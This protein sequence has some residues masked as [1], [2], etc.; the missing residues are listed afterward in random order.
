[1]DTELK[2]EDNNSEFINKKRERNRKFKQKKKD[3]KVLKQ[4]KQKAQEKLYE[5]K[6]IPNPSMSNNIIGML[7][8]E[9]QTSNNTPSNITK[10]KQSKFNK[11]KDI[12]EAQKKSILSDSNKVSLE[13]V[14]HDQ[15]YDKPKLINKEVSNV[16]NLT[17]IPKLTNSIKPTQHTKPIT[18]ATLNKENNS[19]TQVHKVKKE[20]TSNTP[21]NENPT[22][23]ANSTFHKEH[24][25]Q[26]T[27]TPKKE[28]HSKSTNSIKVPEKIKNIEDLLINARRLYEERAQEYDLE[29]FLTMDPSKQKKY[30]DKKWTAEIIKTGTF[31]DKISALALYIKSE[32]KYTLKY[33]D[34]LI[35]MAKKKNRRQTELCVANF[36]NVVYFLSS[37]IVSKN[38]SLSVAT[39]SSV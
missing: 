39:H 3:K 38:K 29:F 33:L 28:K 22:I 31:E 7:K 23:Q 9:N 35:K 20:K 13:K 17:K 34:M 25:V 12:N 10:K 5:E 1:M 30:K 19:E 37:N 15:H 21:N 8:K 18:T 32:P 16:T 27:N 2:S 4:E 26:T 6:N 14:K 11:Y 24:P 36:K